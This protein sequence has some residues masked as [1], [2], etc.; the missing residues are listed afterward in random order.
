[1]VL[2]SVI[3]VVLFLLACP[4]VAE[5]LLRLPIGDP[6]R[7]GREVPLVLD[8]VTDAHT[9]DLL[10][11]AELPARLAGVDI[12]L[13]GESHTSV[14]FHRVQ[15]RVLDEL[16]R[17][18]RKVMIGLEMFPYTYQEHLD[19][20]VSGHYS[21]EGV[22]ELGDWYGAWGYHWDYYRDLFVLARDRGMPMFAINTPREVVSA[23][24]EKGFQDLT[25]EEAAHIPS[26]IDTE[27]EEH[28]RLFKA[29]FD[30]D[31]PIHAQM[32]EDAWM[33]M[34]RAQCT[35]DA[36][37]GFNSVKAFEKHRE[38]G[39]ILVV[40]A[41][42]GHVSYG[43]GIERQAAQW[44]DG[45]VASLIPVSVRDGDGEPV[46]SVQA[47]YADFLWGLPQDTGPIYPS[48]GISTRKN[49]DDRRELIYVAEDTPAERAGF[50]VG[51]LLVAADG[52]AIDSKGAFS[53]LM[54]T[55][56]WGDTI[57]VTVERGEETVTI[58]A[59]LRRKLETDEEADDE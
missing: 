7:S 23:V 47:S 46:A 22:L 4:V 45:E 32:S 1:M 34:L 41:G 25:E 17:A 40:L 49:D 36:T 39:A 28:L 50:Q 11:P 19:N 51:D 18:G 59:M 21:E 26:E 44:F 6:A 33:S 27:S 9:G 31:D 10:T 30:E 57:S 5:D 3:P 42:S 29:Y 58:E 54:A 2:R 35:W 12:L 43:L 56:R 38:E 55:K 15:Y 16:S 53:R 24:R 37:M 52:V 13:V 14:D 8:A 20:W 48:L